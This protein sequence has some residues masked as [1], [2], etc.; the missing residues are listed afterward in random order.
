VMR[1]WRV[2]DGDRAGAQHGTGWCGGSDSGR[3]DDQQLPASSPPD[4]EVALYD[5]GHPVEWAPLTL[6]L[7]GLQQ[8]GSAGPVPALPRRGQRRPREWHRQRVARR[9]V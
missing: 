6:Q 4:H 9:N 7:A 2:S 5:Y 3:H 8:R 1:E